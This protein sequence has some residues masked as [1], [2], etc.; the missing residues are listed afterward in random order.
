MQLTPTTRWVR[1]SKDRLHKVLTIESIRGKPSGEEKPPYN[2][3]R[4]TGGP[5]RKL[6]DKAAAA[7]PSPASAP[8][9]KAAASPI[10]SNSLDGNSAIKKG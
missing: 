8:S 9:V 5:R 6:T 2:L 3:Y 10:L 7:S 1:W 4:R